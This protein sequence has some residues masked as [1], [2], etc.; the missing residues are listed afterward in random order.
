MVWRGRQW[1]ICFFGVSLIFPYGVTFFIINGVL[2][3]CPG[4][5]ER[6]VE[7]WEWEGVVEFEV[8]IFAILWSIWKESNDKN[9]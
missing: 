7:T 3:S 1:T 5:L 9:F 8:F 4:S 6:L 2:W